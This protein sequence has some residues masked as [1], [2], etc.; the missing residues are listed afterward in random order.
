MEPENYF[1]HEDFLSIFD[2]NTSDTITELGTAVSQ[3]SEA[4]LRQIEVTIKKY[5]REK[6]AERSAE[7]GEQSDLHPGGGNYL[8][9]VDLQLSFMPPV[10]PSQREQMEA[11]QCPG[12]HNSP[13][14]PRGWLPPPEQNSAAC[15]RADRSTP[16]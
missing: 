7:H 13:S 1:E 9:G 11:R 16:R 8:V 15:G 10:I 2:F 12:G 14:P 5:E 4:V 6:S 3:G